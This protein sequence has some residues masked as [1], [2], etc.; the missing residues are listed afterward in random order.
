[1][2]TVLLCM[3]YDIDT[4]K[5]YYHPVNQLYHTLIRHLFLSFVRHLLAHCKENPETSSINNK[6]L[7]NISKTSLLQNA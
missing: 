2:F 7:E 3:L 5:T 1:M 6:N 4:Q